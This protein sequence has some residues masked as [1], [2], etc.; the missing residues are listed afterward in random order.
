MKQLLTLV[1]VILLSG[2][3]ATT[4]LAKRELKDYGDKT[5]AYDAKDDN[6]NAK[7]DKTLEKAA[8]IQEKR[9]ARRLAVDEGQ[10]VRKKNI[11]NNNPGKNFQLSGK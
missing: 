6:I 3:L 10:K 4:A 9:E 7:H 1:M 5:K 8:K 11:K 2:S